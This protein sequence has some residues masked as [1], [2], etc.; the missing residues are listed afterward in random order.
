MRGLGLPRLRPTMRVDKDRV[1]GDCED[2]VIRIWIRMKIE[3]QVRTAVEWMTVMC[4]KSH[5]LKLQFS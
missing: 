2:V 3:G 1:L 5:G 4:F